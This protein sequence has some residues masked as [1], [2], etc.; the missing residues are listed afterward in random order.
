MFFLAGVL[1]GEATLHLKQLT[2]F[3]MLCRLPGNILHRIAREILT[4]S[5]QSD[6]NWYANVRDLCFQYNLPHPLVL[7]SQ[8]Q[9]KESFKRLIKSQ[10]TDFWQSKLRAHAA[11]LP[12]LRYFKPQFMS[13][14]SPHQMWSTATDSYSVNKTVTVA[15]MLSGRYRCGSLLRH[16]SK[17]VSGTCELCEHDVETIEHILLPECPQLLENKEHVLNYSRKKLKNYPECLRL[18]N[19]A[20]SSKNPTLTTQFLLDP[21]V[22]PEV[23]HSNQKDNTV[24]PQLL[25]VT[26]TW[27]YSMHRARLKFVEQISK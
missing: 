24:I 16:F 6:K 19:F 2:L 27:C 12:S 9:S 26:S 10:V 3:G 8:P 23:I 1:P 13:L 18:F 25:L 21:T 20:I 11:S 14:S 5:S 4:C 15:R 7:L 22:L 17:S